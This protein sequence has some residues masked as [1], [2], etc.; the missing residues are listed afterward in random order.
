MRVAFCL[1]LLVC[2][3]SCSLPDL[4]T[5]NIPFSIGRQAGLVRSPIR[6]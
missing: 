2:F 1:G 5:T 6:N 3:E 4:E